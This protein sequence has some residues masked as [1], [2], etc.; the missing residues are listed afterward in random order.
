MSFNR[1]KLVAMPV[2]VMGVSSP[3][4]VNCSSVPSGVLPDQVKDVADAAGGCDEMASGDFASLDMKGDAKANAKV[5]G[6]LEAAFSLKKVSADMEADLSASCTTIGKGLGMTDD[7]L[8]GEGAEKI[9]GAV[10]AK[11]DVAVKGQAEAKLA[12]DFQEPKCYVDVEAMQK[13]FADCDVAIS[14]GELKASCQ[15]GEISGKCDA[16]CKGTCSVDA[17]AACTGSC[18]AQCSGKCDANFSGK[19]GG[20]CDGKCDGK[21]TRGKCAGSCEGKCDAQAEGSCGGTCDGKCSGGCEVKATGKCEGSCSG[22]CSAEMKAPKCSGEFRPPK[23]DATCQ[24]N[25]GAK[26]AGSVKCDPPR[27]T[28]VARGKANA[29]TP[30]LVSALQAG[31]PGVIKVQLGLGKRVL[32]AADNL[33]GAGAAMGDA[34]LKVG[35]KAAACVKAAVDASVSA[36]AS[37][38]VN[39]KASASVSGSAKG[40]T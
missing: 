14:P 6:F 30:K 16:E 3:L 38:N 21:N 5:R 26:A 36:T 15:G 8:K 34:A 28:I 18:S 24:T 12:V 19:C 7:E 35:G 4:L 2:L 17:G 22:G 23:V 27:L 11:L 20:T 39:V 31:L 9:C 10:K 33:K 25:C 37:V 13:C 32:T 40:G 1:W 29:E